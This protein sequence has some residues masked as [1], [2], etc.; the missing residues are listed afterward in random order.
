MAGA[1]IKAAIPLSPL[2][3]AVVDHNPADV[4]FIARVLEA[5]ALPYVGIFA[6]PP[7]CRA[8]HEGGHL[9]YRIMSSSLRISKRVNGFA[10]YY[11][12]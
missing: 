8:P 3:I 12:A 2:V 7:S 6:Y 9:K 10:C 5:H 4:Y 1:V 11:S